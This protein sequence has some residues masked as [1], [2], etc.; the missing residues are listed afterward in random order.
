MQ[1]EQT[2]N[3]QKNIGRGTN[4]KHWSQVLNCHI[5]IK[6]IPAMT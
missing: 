6:R 3:K 1:E 5:C 4:H 2:Q